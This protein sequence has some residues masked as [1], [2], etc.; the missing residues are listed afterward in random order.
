MFSFL[1]VNELVFWGKYIPC[2]RYSVGLEIEYKCLHLSLVTEKHFTVSSINSCEPMTQAKTER[3]W[4]IYW[5]ELQSLICFSMGL[6]CNVSDRVWYAKL[7]HQLS[8]HSTGEFKNF[9]FSHALNFPRAFSDCFSVQRQS[10]Q[11]S[12]DDCS[13]IQWGVSRSELVSS[14]RSNL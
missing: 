6:C 9:Y 10:L 8:C 12:L 13:V 11:E 5:K 7:G 14:R 4:R 1:P 3:G 2:A